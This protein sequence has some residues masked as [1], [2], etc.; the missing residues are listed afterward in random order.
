MATSSNKA[1]VYLSIYL[2]PLTKEVFEKHFSVIG[3]GSD[4]GGWSDEV[5]LY[6]DDQVWEDFTEMHEASIYKLDVILDMTY[7]YYSGFDGYCDESEC[8]IFVDRL[9]CLER[10]DNFS[11]LRLVVEDVIL[12]DRVRKNVKKAIGFID[13]LQLNKG[14]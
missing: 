2:R 13:Q 10:A 5:D 7:R 8:E 11:Q 12:K 6:L 9:L 1:K 3:F 14:K 4:I